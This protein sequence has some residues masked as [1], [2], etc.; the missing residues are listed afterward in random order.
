MSNRPIIVGVDD[1]AGSSAAL[2]WAADEARLRG[3]SL[4]VVHAP[5]A[6]RGDLVTANGVPGLRA[7]DAFA[8]RILGAHATAASARQPG[9]PVTTLLGHGEPGDTLIDLSVGAAMVV[10]GM[11]EPHALHLGVTRRVAA[12]AHSAVVIIPAGVSMPAPGG[13]VVLV[14]TGGPADEH[15]RAVAREEADLRGVRLRTLGPAEGETAARTVL[16]EARR[17]CLVVLPTTRAGNSGPDAAGALVGHLLAGAACPLMV[18][19]AP[20]DLAPRWPGPAL[21]GF[22]S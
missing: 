10:L 18:V 21:T 17:A 1:S 13:R 16:A 8:D 2:F 7:L 19:T 14:P 12:H 22:L 20:S 4:L 3:R 5:V 15:A 11:H 9:V 6:V